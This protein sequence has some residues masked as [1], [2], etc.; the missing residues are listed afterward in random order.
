M[1]NGAIKFLQNL[2]NKSIDDVD[3]LLKDSNIIQNLPSISTG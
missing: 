1:K 2:K 3:E